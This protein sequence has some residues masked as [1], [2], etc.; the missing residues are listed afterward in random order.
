MPSAAK[1]LFLNPLELAG[2]APLL[3]NFYNAIENILKQTLKT[4]LAP[5]LDGESWHKELLILAVKQKWISETPM[6]DLK[7]Y[8]AFQ[9]YFSHGYALDLHAEKMEPLVQNP[10]T[11]YSKLQEDIRAFLEGAI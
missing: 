2:V 1:L 10:R 7:Q 11:A 3:H 9:H 6:S 4:S 5:L 8:L